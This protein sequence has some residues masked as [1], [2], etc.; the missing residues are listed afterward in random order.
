MFQAP[1]LLD[2][3]SKL[4]S[5]VSIKLKNT[6]ANRGKGHLDKILDSSSFSS[7]VVEG[8]IKTNHQ[9]KV[10]FLCTSHIMDL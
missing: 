9:I 7:S 1:N 6:M 5:F 10:I 2:K 8:K 3:L 4:L